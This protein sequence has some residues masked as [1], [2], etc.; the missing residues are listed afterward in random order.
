MADIYCDDS[1]LY[2]HGLPRGAAPNPGRLAASVDAVGNFIVLD[3]HGFASDDEV[4]FRAEAGGSLPAPLAA[5]VTYY[6]LPLGESTFSVRATPGGAAIDLTSAGSKVLCIA[7]LPL[8]AT[9]AWASRL[10]DDFLAGHPV[11]LEAP[12]PEIVRF[13]AAELAAGKLLALMGGASKSLS[14]IEGEARKRIERWGKGLPVRGEGS[15][16]PAQ[17]AAS[18]SVP[19]SDPRGWSRW[20]G[21]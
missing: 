21:L 7:P 2:A 11:P 17:L 1:D 18:A 6:A 15:Q 19:Y 3:A 5:N 20:G 8:A 14:D 16:Q 10:I 13:T 12:I 9:R 4:R